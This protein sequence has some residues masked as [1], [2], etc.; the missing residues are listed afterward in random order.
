MFVSLILAFFGLAAAY[1]S[2]CSRIVGSGEAVPAPTEQVDG[3]RPD[4]E[5]AA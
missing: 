5:V 1:V 4:E 2:A 3:D